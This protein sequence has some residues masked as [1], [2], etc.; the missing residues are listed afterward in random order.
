MANQPQGT[1]GRGTRRVS[2]AVAELPGVESLIH[3][4]ETD[5]Y[6][7]PAAKQ[8]ELLT[9]WERHSAWLESLKLD[10][11]EAFSGPDPDVDGAIN[12]G[13]PSVSDH[14]QGEP[15]VHAVEDAT[16]DEV[17][18]ALHISLGAA[19]HRIAVARDL[20]HKLPE[21]RRL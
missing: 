2:F 5:P 4:I 12:V 9:A 8:L 16:C 21:T 6:S 19:R 20:A 13:S 17:A 7:L 1:S 11:L 3:L 14:T 15:D 10:A 18:A